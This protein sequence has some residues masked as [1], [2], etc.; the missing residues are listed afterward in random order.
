MAPVFV[1]LAIKFV[2]NMASRS[3]EISEALHFT[4]SEH[5]VDNPGGIESNKFEMML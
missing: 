5:L 4:V 1:T 2:R 3:K